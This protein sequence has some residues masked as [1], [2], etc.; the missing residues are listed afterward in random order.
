MISHLSNLSKLSFTDDELEK[1]SNDMSSLVKIV[2]TI[3]EVDIEYIP[4]ADNKNI[5]V[6]DLRRDIAKDSMATE[7]I[8]KNAINSD[9]CFV[10]P[11]VVE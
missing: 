6:N 11:K 3:K 4:I 1:F 9:S 8:L 10:V 7:N 5:Y 2:D